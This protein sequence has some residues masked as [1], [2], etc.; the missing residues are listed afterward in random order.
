MATDKISADDRLLRRRQAARVRQQR[1]RARKRQASVEAPEAEKQIA[2]LKHPFAVPSSER[3]FSRHP[4][5]LRSDRSPRS[6]YTREVWAPRAE[7]S[8]R[9]HPPFDRRPCVPFSF[10]PKL[11]PRHN[12]EIKSH[13]VPVYAHY[14][15]SRRPVQPQF[16]SFQHRRPCY[17][18]GEYVATERDME[19]YP[20]TVPEQEYRQ[21]TQTWVHPVS[22]QSTAPYAMEEAVAP[23]MSKEEAAIDA[24]LSL[25]SGKLSNVSASPSPVKRTFSREQGETSAFRRISQ[26]SHPPLRP[27]VYMTVR[28]A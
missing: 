1:C 25:K 3:Q 28:I 11:Q 24:I 9:P 6:V 7:Y 8:K 10:E 14:Q 23:M 21:P 4:L 5:H 19:Y 20:H 18:Y 15:P 17:H 2:P 16:L 12:S 22:P 27:A 26:S 13:L